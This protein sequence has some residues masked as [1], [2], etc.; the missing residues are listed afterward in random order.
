MILMSIERTN[1]TSSRTSLAWL[2]GSLAAIRPQTIASA[3]GRLL[4]LNR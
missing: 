3:S 4:L 1:G 2:Y